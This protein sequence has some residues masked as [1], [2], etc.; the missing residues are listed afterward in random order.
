MNNPGTKTNIVADLEVCKGAGSEKRIKLTAPSHVAFTAYVG[1]G[2]SCASARACMD[3]IDE[4]D[5]DM[6]NKYSGYFDA[7]LLGI[8]SYIDDKCKD[9]SKNDQLNNVFEELDELDKLEYLKLDIKKAL[10]IDDG[11]LDDYLPN[12]PRGAT[13]VIN[14]CY[15]D[16]PRTT[17]VSNNYLSDNGMD[18]NYVQKDLSININKGMCQEQAS[19]IG[20]LMKSGATE[21][22]D[23]VLVI[24]GKKMPTKVSVYY[25]AEGLQDTERLLKDCKPGLEDDNS[26]SDSDSNSDDGDNDDDLGLW[27]GLGGGLLVFVILL[28]VAAAY[29]LKRPRR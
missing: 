19:C 1:N 22:T 10:G 27:L 3:N 5:E 12:I 17:L 20:S 18:S 29:F 11:G 21:T 2:L 25:T 9:V 8:S 16:I 23:R 14:Q 26:D 4:F 24:D 7:P 15:G 6:K 13:L 28:L